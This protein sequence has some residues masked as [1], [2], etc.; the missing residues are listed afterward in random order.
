MKK[1]TLLLVSLLSFATCE[2]N[3]LEDETTYPGEEEFQSADTVAFFL[4][5]L[6]WI[7][8]GRSPGWEFGWKENNF[9]GLH[10]MDPET[11]LHSVILSGR[12]S[13]YKR[14]VETFDQSVRIA[15]KGIPAETGEILLGS[16]EEQFMEIEDF[17][18]DR[19]YRTI[20]DDPILLEVTTFDTIIGRVE[21][22]FEGQLYQVETGEP[23]DI[24]RGRFALSF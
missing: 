10:L 2:V 12:M 11:G 13:F 16:G 24:T 8:F 15:L 4:N 5:D 23:V 19:S 9:Q 18:F 20:D 17:H 1:L 3:T 14:S 21:G 22:L 7:P 6:L